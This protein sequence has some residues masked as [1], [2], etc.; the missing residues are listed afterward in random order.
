MKISLNWLSEYIK[1]D[2]SPA[3]LAEKLTG[4]GLEVESVENVESVP[5]GLQGLVVGEVVEK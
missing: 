5:G 2:L 1:I 3:Q 4:C